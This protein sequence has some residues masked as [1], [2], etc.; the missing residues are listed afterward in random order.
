MTARQRYG[1]LLLA[2]L[3]GVEISL[4]CT[5]GGVVGGECR[6]GL[7]VCG[8]ACV[9]LS[10]DPQNCGA[11][12]QICP[13]GSAC[14]S[15]ACVAGDAGDAADGATSDVAADGASS[16]AEGDADTTVIDAPLHDVPGDQIATDAEAGPPDSPGDGA[17]TPPFDTPD[18][19][20]NCQTACPSTAP[21]CVPVDGGF[22]CAPKCPAPLLDCAGVCID[23]ST[24]PDHCGFCGN[25]CPSGICQD[26]KCIGAT[27]GHVVLFCVSFEQTFQASPQTVMLGNAVFLPPGNPVRIL[28]Y[29]EYT[30]NSIQNKLNQALGWAASAKGRTYSLSSSTTQ[31]T[32]PQQL[33]K[34]A[35]DVFILYDQP[36]APAGVLGPTGAAWAATLASF[37]A[38][39]GVIV[40]ATG[41]GGS[42]E[43]D[44]MVDSAGLL[45]TTGQSLLTAGT[46]L[47]NI[48]PFDAIGVNALS[49]FT[50]LKQTCT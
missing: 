38:Q 17:C 45:P 12:D 30:P 18:Q 48:A 2:A 35:F 42:A 14:T 9:D 40:V 43:V 39:G 44:E 27:A 1:S 20:G 10:T 22:A 25:A 21:L 6:P 24:D 49:Q 32:I 41:G 29:T 46:I 13:A 11:C 5:S 37:V 3:A 36:N 8:G 47:F 23:T 16:D 7:H 28:G 4:A 19:C 15:A 33:D 26:G 31:S 50:A 34:S